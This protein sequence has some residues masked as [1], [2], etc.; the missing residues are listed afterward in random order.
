MQFLFLFVFGQKKNTQ[1][2]FKDV[3][4]KK[5]KQT[6][7][8]YKNKLFHSLKNRIFPK[9]LTHAFS[10]K[11]EF[12]SLVVFSKKGLEIRLNN[13]LDRKETYF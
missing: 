10:Q 1:I 2:R 13:V 8:D 7:F 11:M 5:K 4:D 3:L 12:F 6:V 9:G